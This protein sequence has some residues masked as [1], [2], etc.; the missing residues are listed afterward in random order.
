MLQ[1]AGLDPGSRLALIRGW[2]T[3]T[4]VIKNGALTAAERAALLAFCRQRSFDVGYYPGIRAGQANRYNRLDQAYYYQAA[5][6]LL[7]PERET[8]FERYKFDLRPVGDDRPFFF[9]FSKWSTLPELLT[10]QAGGGFG[11]LEWGYLVLLAA[12][13]QALLAGLA[14][15]VLPL[16]IS[17]RTRH[18]LRGVG[19]RVFG[20]FAAIGLGF[21][22]IEIAFI[23]KLLLLLG[24]PVYAVAVVLSAFLLFAGLG[25]GYSERLR[26]ANRPQRLGL[27][28]ALLA[29]I[30]AAVLVPALLAVGL[31][32]PLPVKAL[33]AVMLIAPL[34]F[35]L[36]M[37]FPWGLRRLGPAQ[38][39]WAWAINGCASV[40]S[41]LLAA[42]LAVEIG[43][44]GLL[45]AGAGLYLLAG[46]VAPG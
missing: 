32:W 28:I 17:R 24:H 36:G 37:P 19:W 5:L 29:G 6:A 27:S 33:C 31:A 44:S 23:Q 1:Q 13:L 26:F 38:L 41:A 25:S 21:L 7:G 15:I 11:Q 3:V 10:L 35:L 9:H 18:S 20:Y 12:L 14:L 46:R 8:F 39:P 34:G 45:L 43:F 42:L 30:E 2:K 16:L 4:V 40:V 22:L